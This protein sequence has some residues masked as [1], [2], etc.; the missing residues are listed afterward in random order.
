[1]VSN[2]AQLDKENEYVYEDF[3]MSTAPG[4]KQPANQQCASWSTG[5]GIRTDDKVIKKKSGWCIAICIL[6]TVLAIIA[7]TALAVGALSLRGSTEA[8]LAVEVLAE[9][10]DSVIKLYLPD[11]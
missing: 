5:A 1:M 8:Q 3:Q 11:G 10:S 7:F 4:K 2:I 9:E 6:I